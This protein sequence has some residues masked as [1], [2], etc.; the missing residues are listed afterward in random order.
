MKFKDFAV[1]QGLFETLCV[2]GL[3]KTQVFENFAKI[4]LVFF[5]NRP[6]FKTREQKALVKNQGKTLEYAIFAGFSLLFADSP[7]F[8]IKKLAFFAFCCIFFRKFAG[9]LRISR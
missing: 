4:F 7:F 1:E 3:Q 6:F 9:F 5:A 2:V 8:L